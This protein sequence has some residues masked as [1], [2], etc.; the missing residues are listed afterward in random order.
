MAGFTSATRQN[1]HA[2][3]RLLT[4]Q[5]A[6]ITTLLEYVP[7]EFVVSAFGFLHAKNVRLN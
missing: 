5:L 7:R 1:R 4:K 2:V 6:L 3:I